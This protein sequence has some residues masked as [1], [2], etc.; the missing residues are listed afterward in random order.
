MDL[1]K[2]FDTINQDLL[3]AKLHAYDVST[4][5]LKVI[6]CNV[7]LN[8]DKLIGHAILAPFWAMLCGFLRRTW[9]GSFEILW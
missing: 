4:N 2:A 8:L 5:P 7:R 3:L 9:G 6:L 1:S